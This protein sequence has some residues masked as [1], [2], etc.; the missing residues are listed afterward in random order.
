MDI[1]F[2]IGNVILEWNPQR[3]VGSLFS[4]KMESK[5]VIENIIA[6]EDWQML[7]K[8]TLSLEEAISR[9]NGRCNIGVDKIRKLFEETP[10]SLI[11][12]QE[13]INVIMELS[14][15]GYNLYVLS[16]MHKHSFEYLSATYDIWKCFSGIVISSHIKSIKPEPEIFKYLIGT[17]DL[18]PSNTVFLDDNKSNIGAARKFGLNTIH[19]KNASQSKKKLYQM[20]GI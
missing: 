4:C 6:H 16:N 7:D 13:T 5:E 1:V 2:D 19:V 9:A 12:I 8:G 3:L 20:I 17:Y 10:K 14:E 11:P 15:K 18:I